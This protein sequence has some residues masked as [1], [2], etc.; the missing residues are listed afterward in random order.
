MT[1]D[2]DS[3]VLDLLSRMTDDS[4]VAARLD[5]RT[6][7]LARIAALVAVNAPPA[8]YLANLGAASD[9]EVDVEQIRGLLLAIAP[10]V[11]TVRIT[12]ALGN[13]ARALGIAVEAA[14]GSE[15]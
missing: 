3:R 14:E 8:S 2:S 4:I 6:W 15:S 11:G 9:L 7:I 10:V 13:M 12:S 1:S 5:S